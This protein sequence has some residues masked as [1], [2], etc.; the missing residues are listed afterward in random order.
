MQALTQ[1]ILKQENSIDRPK[2][3]TALISDTV[4]V[5]RK[6]EEKKKRDLDA[7][8]KEQR[9]VTKLPSVKR[10][11]SSRNK[12]RMDMM[13]SLEMTRKNNN[14]RGIHSSTSNLDLG[15]RPTSSML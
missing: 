14:S 5:E 15:S 9:M 7:Y 10:S 2:T 12:E 13:K 11:S 4:S 1:S 3:L 6:L 8:I